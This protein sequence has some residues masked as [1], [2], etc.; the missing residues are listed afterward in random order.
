MNRFRVVRIPLLVLALLGAGGWNLYSM[1]GGSGDKS[2][3]G[4]PVPDES[5]RP[6]GARTATFAAGCFWCVEEVFH[7]VDG[8]VSAVSGY[9]GGSKEN[10]QYSQ[11]AAG[12]TD[13][14]E[15]V[16][17]I[18]IPSVLGYDDLLEWFFKLHD[19]TQV[20]RQGPDVGRQYRSAIF[21]HNEEQRAAA[22]AAKQRL[23]ASGRYDKPI[24]TEI[25]P[26]Q[27]FYPAEAYHQNFARRNPGN[28]YIQFHLQPKLKKLGLKTL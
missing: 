2:A 5:N 22:V 6:D 17:V 19:P 7:Q 9:M 1:V 24:A 28:R 3:G 25:V 11:V 27:E 21:Y 20:D 12:R 16:Q 18:F 23:D 10:A 14:A 26:A 8:V 4:L 15:S 13:H